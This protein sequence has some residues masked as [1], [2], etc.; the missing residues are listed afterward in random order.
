MRVLSYLYSTLTDHA[1]CLLLM[2]LVLQCLIYTVGAFTAF[3]VLALVRGVSLH[4]DTTTYFLVMPFTTKKF[5][6]KQAASV[7][8]A[9]L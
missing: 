7:N 1:S 4:V 9:R 5:T 6:N 8:R 3:P 2:H